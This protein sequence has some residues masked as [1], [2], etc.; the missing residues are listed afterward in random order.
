MDDDAE[1]GRLFALARKSGK[2]FSMG[3]PMLDD[4]ARVVQALQ[5]IIIL[6]VP[7]LFSGLTRTPPRE[8]LLSLLDTFVAYARHDGRYSPAD[9]EP[10]P[11]EQREELGLKLRALVEAWTP[12]A[13]PSEITQAARELLHAEGRNAPPEGWDALSEDMNEEELLWPEGVPT[14]LK[15]A[16]SSNAAGGAL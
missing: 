7:R 13:M 10:V 14:L 5:W 1:Q 3:R 9:F 11:Y 2:A 6:A 4:V 12:P 16:G 15:L 8:H